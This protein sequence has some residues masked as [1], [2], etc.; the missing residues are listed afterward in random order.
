M[1]LPVCRCGTVYHLSCDRTSATDISNDNWKCFCSSVKL[2]VM[3]R[4]CLLICAL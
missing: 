4:D 2:T 1:L 3:H